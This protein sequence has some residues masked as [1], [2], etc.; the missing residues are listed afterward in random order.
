MKSKQFTIVTSAS[1]SATFASDSVDL[2]FNFGAAIQIVVSANSSLSA[3]AT[4]QAS[5]DGTNWAATSA[6]ATLN[7][8]G[9][10]VINV[11]DIMYPHLRVNT[12]VS[13][14][15]ATIEM[16]ASVKGV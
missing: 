5:V 1:K 2:E 9:V 11:T 3:V 15:S 14:G 12:V 13:S 6:T 4:V 10:T 8:N 7:A 16:K